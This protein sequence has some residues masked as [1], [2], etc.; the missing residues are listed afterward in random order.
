MRRPVRFAVAVALLAAATAACTDDGAP[1][2]KGT[3]PAW[4]LDGLAAA[5]VDS[6]IQ[7]AV[8]APPAKAP[9]KVLGV[10]RISATD[11]VLA[12]RNNTCQALFLPDKTTGQVTTAPTSIGA[13][14][15]EA[16]TAS[17][18]NHDQFPG[19][20]LAG[21]YTQASSPMEPF[22]FVTLGC[23]EKGMVLKIEGAGESAQVQKKAG[24]SLRSWT[25]G[26][27]VLVA[28]GAADAIQASGS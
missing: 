26:R 22:A 24:D 2:G 12:L 3:P 10:A 11:V 23:S 18:D 20:V 1:Q 19:T 27:D 16:G 6:A 5:P 17:S 28:V 21:T 9:T 7:S 14:R 4:P 13:Q 25:S 8:D 15:P